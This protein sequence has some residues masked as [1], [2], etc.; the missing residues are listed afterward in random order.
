MHVCAIRHACPYRCCNQSACMALHALTEAHFLHKQLPC[1]LATNP[2]AQFVMQQCRQCFLLHSVGSLGLGVGEG[3]SVAQPCSGTAAGNTL[4]YRSSMNTHN[5]F[6]LA[7]CT[8][9][10]VPESQEM[11]FPLSSVMALFV[12]LHHN[13]CWKAPKHSMYKH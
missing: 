9:Y 10:C 8:V 4:P 11:R 12:Q 1:W 2:E 5:H 3:R 7:C 6:V 13:N